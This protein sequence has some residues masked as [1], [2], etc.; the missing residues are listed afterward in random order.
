MNKKAKIRLTVVLIDGSKLVISEKHR[1][2]VWENLERGD[3]SNLSSFKVIKLPS[4]PS[5]DDFSL[6]SLENAL[7][8]DSDFSCGIL[9]QTTENIFSSPNSRKSSSL[10]TNTRFSDLENSASLPFEIPFG[11]E[12]ILTPCCLRNISSPNLTF[13]SLRN[14][15]LEGDV[16]DDILFTPCQISCIMQGCF[17]MFFSQRRI[18]FE[19][20]LDGHSAFKHFQDL[21]NHNS[22]AF[23]SRLSMADFTIRDNIFVN[24]D[25]HR[26][27]VGNPLFKTFVSKNE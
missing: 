8:K 20:F 2:Y 18:I 23:E 3:I 15:I 6:S 14:L 19:N 4:K 7:N 10:V 5:G 24:F 17:D 22:S 21:P 25:S 13:S 9:S 16:D 11:F 26:S 12:I 1:L 27:Q